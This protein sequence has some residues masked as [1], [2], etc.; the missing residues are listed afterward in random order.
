MKRESIVIYSSYAKAFKRLPAEQYMRLMTA[1]ID[2]ATE[3]IIPDL[4]PIEMVIFDIAKRE[5]DS[6]NQKFQEKVENAK[7]GGAPIGNQNAKKRTNIEDCQENTEDFE[8]NLKQPKTTEN[9]QKQ[10]KTTENNLYNENEYVNENEFKENKK[11]KN[12]IT[13]CVCAHEDILQ[14]WSKALYE[15]QKSVSGITYAT[16]FDRIEFLDVSDNSF[17]LKTSEF[18]RNFIDEKYKEKL[19]CAIKNASD[20]KFDN[21]VWG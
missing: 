4:E 10:P 14:I 3:D 11:N 7:K 8:N 6:N 20:K 15:I 9:N 21:Y 2:Y 16:Y 12:K 18:T 17:V 1:I 19:K 5:I 13:A